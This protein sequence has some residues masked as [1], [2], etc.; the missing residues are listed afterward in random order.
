[1]RC[2]KIPLRSL[3]ELRSYPPV[4]FLKNPSGG[5]ADQFQYRGYVI[6]LAAEADVWNTP[7]GEKGWRVSVQPLNPTLAILPRAS[8]GLFD[9][10][11]LALAHCKELIDGLLEFEG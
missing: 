7:K 11:E 8:F 3:Q 6:Y 2:N 10:R 1:M 5:M 9:T 4:F